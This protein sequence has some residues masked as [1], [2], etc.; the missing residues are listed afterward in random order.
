MLPK[1]HYSLNVCRYSY[2]PCF[3]SV[4]GKSV[5]NSRRAAPRRTA[6]AACGTGTAVFA[7]NHIGSVYFIQFKKRFKIYRKYKKKSSLY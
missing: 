6:A 2:V 5:K 1:K 4:L 7:A 3:V